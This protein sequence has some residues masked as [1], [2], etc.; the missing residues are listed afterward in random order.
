MFKTLRIAVLLFILALVAASAW[1]SQAT[2]VKWKYALPVN[3]YPV[4]ADG[5]A[6]AEA[7]IQRLSVNDFKAIESFMQSQATIHGR[8]FDAGISPVD[9]RLGR[10]VAEVPPAAP[11]GGHALQVALWSLKMRWW[12]WRH[13]ETAGP[14]TQVKVYLL[15]FDPARHPRLD[16]SV[17]LQKGLIGVVKVFAAADMAAQNNVVI[18]HELLHT[19]GATDKYD[20]STGQP[21]FPDGYAEPGREPRLP[22]RFAEIMGGRIPVAPGKAD[23]PDSLNHALI[24]EKTAREI[25]WLPPAP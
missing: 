22:Q 17:A 8:R 21:V 7:F 13:G 24:G 10:P 14:D 15:Y 25:N 23:Q 5:S 18:A 4:N 16:H 11:A 20:P 19:L 12:A 9:L 1:R 3:L 6:A 2:S